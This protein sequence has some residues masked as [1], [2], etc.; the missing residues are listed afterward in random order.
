MA[1]H[2]LQRELLQQDGLLQD[3]PLQLAPLL[4]TRPK[5]FDDESGKSNSDESEVYL[6]TGEVIDDWLLQNISDDAVD[7]EDDEV[8]LK[9]EF[10]NIFDQLRDENETDL[11]H[12]SIDDDDSAIPNDIIDVVNNLE[13]LP[14][15]LPLRQSEQTYQEQEPYW[16][17]CCYYRSHK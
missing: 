2:Q 10:S 4:I 3:T 7:V 6:D 5:Y 1:Q 14:A 11:Q 13:R 8:S 12:L 9:I 15:I 16:K 17:L